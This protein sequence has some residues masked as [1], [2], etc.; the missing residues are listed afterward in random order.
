MTSMSPV[1]SQ[2]YQALA[3]AL[4]AARG[5]TAVLRCVLP[6]FVREFVRVVSWLQ[7]PSF[8]IYPSMQGGKSDLRSLGCSCF[9]LLRLYAFGTYLQGHVPPAMLFH[10]C[11]S[12]KY[13]DATICF[14]DI[15]M[16]EDLRSSKRAPPHSMQK[17]LYNP[18]ISQEI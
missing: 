11:M 16:L 15:D 9:I 18:C 8:F 1:V 6:S 2:A 10:R 4:P 13:I 17:L 12:Q 14:W 5:C 7:E 3:E